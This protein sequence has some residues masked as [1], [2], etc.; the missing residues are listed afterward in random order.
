MVGASVILKAKVF[1]F[2]SAGMASAALA[3]SI[4]FPNVAFA[5]SAAP[6]PNA[7]PT[8]I[9]SV[10]ILTGS[11]INLV[12]SESKVPVRIQND[13]NSDIRVQVHM[14]P[15]NA[16]VS[17]P[18][19]V[20]VVVPANSGINAQVP[21]KAIGNGDV[22]LT[23]WLTSFSGVRLTGDS[24]LRMNVNA[25][26]ELAMTVTF[27]VGVLVLGTIGVLRTRAKLRRKAKAEA[28]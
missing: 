26:L 18:Q 4:F 10:K 22:A 21:V 23:V 17:V 2:I 12:S 27:G 3:A 8:D 25:G 7:L 15:N 1:G 20:E 28:N 13:F 16:R 24:V 11:D 19:A 14:L 5:S 6:V 9:P